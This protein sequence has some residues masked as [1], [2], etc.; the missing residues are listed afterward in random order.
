M[1][2]VDRRILLTFTAAATLFFLLALQVD[3]YNDKNIL[4]SLGTLNDIKK[5]EQRIIVV[6]GLNSSKED[7]NLLN[8]LIDIDLSPW[9][10]TGITKQMVDLGARQGMRANRVQIINGKLF[11]EVSKSARGPSRI[12]YW[13]WGIREI[14]DEFPDEIPDIDFVLNTQ[15]DPQVS[16]VGK[17]P[18]NPASA[19]KFRE[20]I[21]GIVER[22][23][24]PVF[25][26]VK[27]SNHYDLLWPMWTI[28]GEDVEGAGVKTGGFHDLPWKEL[29]PRLV[30]L[31]KENTWSERKS[32]KIFWRGSVKTNPIRRELLRCSKNIVDAA[33]V[34]HK[35]KLG[36][37]IGALDR[38]KYKYLIYLDG[39]SFSSA[40]LPMLVTGAVVLLPNNSPFQTLC[41]RAFRKS[42]FYE[43]FEMTV[44]QG[45]FC[46]TISELAR[47]HIQK[48]EQRMEKLA[49]NGLVFA[50][51]HLSMSAFQRYMMATL[52]RYC[53]LLKYTPTK[54]K[55][56]VEITWKLVKKNVKRAH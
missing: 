18:K 26:A 37:P 56:A 46:N 42:G 48:D 29:H 52:K 24:P 35:L 3:D 28:W 7:I 51:T 31:A 53:K 2:F 50:E 47:L 13:L 39:K 1:R 33:D 40:V 11:A 22:A 54:T 34:Q 4:T 5:N 9:E 25:S 32:R 6:D 16:I 49:Q 8:A 20:Y 27:T 30:Q 15:D 21:P 45:E 17:R 44:N 12:W 10:K 19:K 36:N 23:P 55:E 14:L 43:G 38:V 41:Q